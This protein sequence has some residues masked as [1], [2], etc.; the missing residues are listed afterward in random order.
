MLGVVGEIWK[1]SNFSCSICECCMMLYSFDQVCETILRPG[2]RTSSIFNS[3]HVATRCNRV[4]KRTQHV[5]PTMLQSV[6]LKCC[7]RLAGACKCWANNVG[8][9][10]VEM[11]LSFGR[12]FRLQFRLKT[13]TE[14]LIILN[15]TKKE[16]SCCFI[17]TTDKKLCSIICGSQ[18]RDWDFSKYNN[19][20]YISSLKIF[21]HRA[22]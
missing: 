16:T 19:S 5:A 8:I 22:M 13:L 15:V 20:A 9:Y 11:S 14:T 21:V 6:A 1:L 17:S 12:G 4:A 2:M 3:Q 10:Y 7:D 18:N